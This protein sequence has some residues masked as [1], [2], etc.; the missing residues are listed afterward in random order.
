[1]I[2][3]VRYEV[4]GDHIHCRLFC[5]AQK[6]RTFAFCGDFRIRAEEWADFQQAFQGA[7]FI[8]DS[9]AKAAARE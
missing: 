9:Q 8:G 7:E 4:R 2:W 6:N 3:R 5:A 1:M